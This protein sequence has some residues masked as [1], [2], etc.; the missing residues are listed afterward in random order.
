MRIRT[1]ERLV[2]EGAEAEGRIVLR[3]EFSH[4]SNRMRACMLTAV[5]ALLCT[6]IAM[7][8]TNEEARSHF[9]VL[10]PLPAIQ[11]ILVALMGLA[12][13][14]F[15]L[16]QLFRPAVRQRVVEL[17]DVEAV[18]DEKVGRKSQQWREPFSGY[19]GIR[20]RVSTTSEGA[21]HSML[22]EHRRSKYTLLIAYETHLGNQAMVDAAQRFDLPVLGPESLTREGFLNRLLAGDLL[23]QR[24]S[25]STEQVAGA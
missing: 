1:M 9:A 23:A 10:A 18:V 4:A 2:G 16:T 17:R 24:Q 6:P 21:R 12:A 7:L 15:G 22:L 11:L 20:H 3:Q 19:R 14:A 8:L 25:Q 5:G 13:I